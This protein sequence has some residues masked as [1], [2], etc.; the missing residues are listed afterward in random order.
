MDNPTLVNSISVQVPASANT[1]SPPSTSTAS[2]P[3]SG[4][5][6]DIV[7]VALLASPDNVECILRRGRYPNTH[8]KPGTLVIDIF[9]NHLNANDE[10]VD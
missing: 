3:A 7:Y 10:A 5:I 4:N 8:A 2:I 1:T 9:L 6:A